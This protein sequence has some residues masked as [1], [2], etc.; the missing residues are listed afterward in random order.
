VF[1]LLSFLFSFIMILTLL[2]VPFSSTSFI[3]ILTIGPLLLLLTLAAFRLRG[4]VAKLPRDSKPV[5]RAPSSA[6]RAHTHARPIEG[7]AR[8]QGPAADRGQARPAPPVHVHT[9]LPL[10]GARL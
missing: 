3:L 4:H 5:T 6:F 8:R 2:Q 1:L 10:P 9:R 7:E